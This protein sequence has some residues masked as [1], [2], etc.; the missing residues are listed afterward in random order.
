MN[1]DRMT[2]QTERQADDSGH[3]G[4]DAVEHDQLGKVAQGQCAAAENGDAELSPQNLGQVVGL[5]VADGHTTDDGGGALAAR[6]TAGI[7]QHGD[8][9]GQHGHGGEG[10]L[11]PADDQA[12]EG[13]GDRSGRAATGHDSCTDPTWI[14]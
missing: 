4:G 14:V 13:G 2:V 1:W 9:G 12:G 5:D 3:R 11:V 10:V 7:G 6:I 8:V